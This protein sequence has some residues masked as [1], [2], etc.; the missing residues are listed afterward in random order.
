MMMMHMV[1]RLTKTACNKYDDDGNCVLTSPSLTQDQC[2]LNLVDCAV[3]PVNIQ[4]CYGNNDLTSW[5]FTSTDGSALR[6]QFNSGTIEGFFDDLTIYDG[7]D[8]TGTILFNNNDAGIQD[9]TGLIFQST[10]DSMFLEVDSD[11]SVSCQSGS[12]LE[13]DFT[14]SCATCINPTANYFV[15][16]DCEKLYNKALSMGLE[17]IQEPKDEAYGQRRFLTVDPDGLLI[18]IGSEC[19]PSAEFMAKYMGAQACEIAPLPSR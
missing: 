3:G 10:S 2:V 5:L 13:W 14:V 19:Q 15:V 16:D 7:P 9:F 12:R 6:I 8:N 4:Y 18:D 1:V 11:S 17:I